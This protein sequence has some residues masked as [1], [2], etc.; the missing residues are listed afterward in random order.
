MNFREVQNEINNLVTLI[1][2]NGSSVLSGTRFLVAVDNNRLNNLY[3]M[4][5]NRTNTIPDVDVYYL[6]SDTDY[7]LIINPDNTPSL[8]HLVVI[9]NFEKDSGLLLKTLEKLQEAI[10]YNYGFQ[11]IRADTWVKLTVFTVHDRISNFKENAL[12]LANMLKSYVGFDDNRYFPNTLV[13]HSIIKEYSDIYI[14]ELCSQLLFLTSLQDREALKPLSDDRANPGILF[15]KDDYP[16]VGYEVYE[17]HLPEL[18]LLRHLIGQIE[19]DSSGNNYE[20]EVYIRV[21]NDFKRRLGIDD[22]TESGNVIKRCSEFMPIEITEEKWKKGCY[23]Y[24]TVR[25]TDKKKS[26]MS[27]FRWN[28]ISR[29]I[30]FIDMPSRTNDNW[31]TSNDIYREYILSACSEDTFLEILFHNMPFIRQVTNVNIQQ[32]RSELVNTATKVLSFE[33]IEDVFNATGV[34]QT[35]IDYI[36]NVKD[37]VIIGLNEQLR[38]AYTNFITQLRTQVNRYS[39]VLNTGI[40]ISNAT[41]E[42]IIYFSLDS[43]EMNERLYDYIDNKIRNDVDFM[44]LLNTT[45]NMIDLPRTIMAGNVDRLYTQA[46]K[47]EIDNKYAAN[48]S[49]NVP[50]YKWTVRND[51]NK[52]IVLLL[53]YDCRDHNVMIEPIE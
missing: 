10:K 3:E 37:D 43:G 39:A 46:H 38:N 34:K 26:F 18:I 35:Y 9:C 30:P 2:G 13:V 19:K 52:K 1:L 15:C 32:F 14:S 22:D 6:S 49:D 36:K 53:R 48:L 25:S 28:S 8:V 4:L 47:L 31:R 44:Q 5:K 51:D 20:S 50:G 41:E 11:S 33:G 45:W 42:R 27:K 40:S 23:K 21:Q 16:W 12:S 24:V 7:S 29:E 17:S